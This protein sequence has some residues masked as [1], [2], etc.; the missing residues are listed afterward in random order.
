MLAQH[1]ERAVHFRS[2][3]A[4]D[5][6]GRRRVLRRA[7]RNGLWVILGP[8][9]DLATPAESRAEETDDVRREAYDRLV[10]S[11]SLTALQLATIHALAFERLTVQELAAR[12]GCSRQAIAARV[13]GNSQGQGGAARAAQR[14][15]CL[16]PYL[17]TRHTVEASG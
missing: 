6:W 15:G 3:A 5:C 10:R 4:H 7:R 2:G 16:L 12:D 17:H 1:S 11:G 13:L 8:D 9:L 14:S